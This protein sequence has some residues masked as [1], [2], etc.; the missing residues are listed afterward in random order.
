MI[1][2]IVIVTL[3]ILKQLARGRARA[4]AELQ[5]DLEYVVFIDVCIC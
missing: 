1:I 3:I 2:S 4:A 5:A